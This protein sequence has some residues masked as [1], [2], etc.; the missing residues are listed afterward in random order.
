MRTAINYTKGDAT[1]PQGT[2]NKII[3]HI[4]NDIGGWG[5]GFVIAISN[6]WKSPEKEYRSWHHS[7]KNF[8]L[9]EVQFVQ[10]EDN[11]WIAN[12]IGQHKI[13]K[14]K[15]DVPPIRYNAVEEGLEKVARFA[16]NTNAS[17][18]M[19]RIGCGLAGGTWDK[20]EPI[21]NST[22]IEKNIKVTVYDY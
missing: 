10:V 1:A 14:V 19:P 8:Q 3:V 13:N 20:I 17:V 2:D 18:H 6:K 21:I 5:K 9:G 22:L 4:C 11:I 15:N 16:Q 7:G 12:I